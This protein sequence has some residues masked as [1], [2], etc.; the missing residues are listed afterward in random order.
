MPLALRGHD[1][2]HYEV[3]FKWTGLY[4]MDIIK[5]SL[6]TGLYEVKFMDWTL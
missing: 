4:E 2:T 1:L 5:C 3:K 6:W